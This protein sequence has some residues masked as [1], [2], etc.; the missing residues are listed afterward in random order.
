[1][2]SLVL[3]DSSGELDVEDQRTNRSA[4]GITVVGQRDVEPVFPTTCV[5]ALPVHGSLV[6]QVGRAGSYIR[7]GRLIAAAWFA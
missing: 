1:M 4:S 7:S 6:V 2:R 5:V 3:I